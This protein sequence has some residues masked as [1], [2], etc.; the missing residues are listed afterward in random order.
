MHRVELLGHY[1][2]SNEVFANRLHGIAAGLTSS[3]MGP[4]D[5]P[6]GALRLLELGLMRQAM[7]MSYNDAFLIV[8]IVNLVTLPAVLLLRRPNPEAAAHVEAV[9]E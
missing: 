8:L 6:L 2:L 5:A 1:S 3:G 9:M 7:V 4:V